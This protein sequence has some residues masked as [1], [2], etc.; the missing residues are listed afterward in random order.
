MDTLEW[1][2]LDRLTACLR[3]LVSL[4]TPERICIGGRRKNASRSGVRRPRAEGLVGAPPPRGGGRGGGEERSPAQPR[5]EGEPGPSPA[6]TPGGGWIP[7]GFYV[8]RW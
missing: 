6:V 7:A 8:W 2:E 3:G 4:S 1:T 5:G